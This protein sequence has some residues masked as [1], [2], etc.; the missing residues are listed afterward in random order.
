MI[1][2]LAGRIHI[3]TYAALTHFRLSNSW[4][5]QVP[6][7]ILLK[8]LVT[9][10]FSLTTKCKQNAKWQQKKGSCEKSLHKKRQRQQQTTL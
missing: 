6:N 7:E 10:Q 2:P 4:A 3:H 5:F 8:Q 9:R 1:S